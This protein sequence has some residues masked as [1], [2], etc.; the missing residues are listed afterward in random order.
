MTTPV[1]Q[2]NTKVG[3]KTTKDG[4]IRIPSATGCDKRCIGKV[5]RSYSICDTHHRFR[6][7]Y[8]F[9]DDN[10]MLIYMARLGSSKD[11]LVMCL[12]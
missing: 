11:K 1:K 7:K 5:I 4:V 6:I 9:C 12:L 10:D 8:T 2:K 3:D